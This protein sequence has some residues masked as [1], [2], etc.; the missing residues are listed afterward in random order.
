VKYD[1]QN[2]N[3]LFSGG[4][5]RSVNIWDIRAG[6]CTASIFGPQIVGEAIDIKSDEHILLTGSH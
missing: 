5:D 3:I 4:W 1:N 2:Q 6:K